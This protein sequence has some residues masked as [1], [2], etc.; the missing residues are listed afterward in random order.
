M[1]LVQCSWHQAVVHDLEDLEAW[2][3]LG[4]GEGIVW[5]ANTPG[6]WRRQLPEPVSGRWTLCGLARLPAGLQA[7]VV[8]DLVVLS[9]LSPCLEFL[10]AVSRIS[11]VAV[12]QT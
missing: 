2:G 1:S 12:S 3:R 4:G 8:V 6:R 10:L 7:T 5:C 9:L 11:P